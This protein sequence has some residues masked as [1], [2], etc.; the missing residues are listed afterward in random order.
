MRIHADPDPQPCGGMHGLFPARA[1]PQTRNMVKTYTHTEI[2]RQISTGNK[3]L[4]LGLRR[5]CLQFNSM[6]SIFEIL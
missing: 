1:E 3:H 5:G 2:C 6:D 4:N